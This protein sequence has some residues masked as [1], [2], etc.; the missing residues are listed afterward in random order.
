MQSLYMR[1]IGSMVGSWWTM[2]SLYICIVLYGWELVDNTIVNIQLLL[3]GAPP[4]GAPGVSQS[5]VEWRC[6]GEGSRFSHNKDF[7]WIFSGLIFFFL[8]SGDHVDLIFET[9][10]NISWTY[11][12]TRLHYG[13]CVIHVICQ[14]SFATAVVKAKKLRQRT[15]NLRHLLINDKSA[16]R[17]WNGIWPIE[18]TCF[19][20]FTLNF[21][22][23]CLN[24]HW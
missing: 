22:S 19:W 4:L 21:H 8:L 9:S 6:G 7:C 24:L 5:R 2:Q 17:V 3:Q 11:T 10:P 18:N 20:H 14:N 13:P 23:K 15:H 12:I 1:C 16:L